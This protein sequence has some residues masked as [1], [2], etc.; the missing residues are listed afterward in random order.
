[1]IRSDQYLDDC[2]REKPLPTTE[3]SQSSQPVTKEKWSESSGI[4]NGSMKYEILRPFK[5]CTLKSRMSE[6]GSNQ[7]IDSEYKC[8]QHFPRGGKVQIGKTISEDA[9]ATTR[10]VKVVSN[11][12]NEAEQL[13]QCMSPIVPLWTVRRL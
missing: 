12:H 5:T 10:W 1:M 6:G 4:D 9:W 13:Y 8:L 7:Y 2:C 3:E 11:S